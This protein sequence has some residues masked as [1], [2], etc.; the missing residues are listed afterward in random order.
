MCNHLPL[1]VE[2]TPAPAGGLTDAELLGRVRAISLPMAVSLLAK[3][4]TEARQKLAAGLVD[5]GFVAAIHAP[6]L[7]GDVARCLHWPR[8]HP[9]Q[10]APGVMSRC[11]VVTPEDFQCITGFVR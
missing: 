3:E 6:Y 4:L 1:L 9:R 8:R 2:I 5:E 7:P 11:D 10:G